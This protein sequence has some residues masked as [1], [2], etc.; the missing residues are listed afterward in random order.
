MKL[1]CFTFSMIFLGLSYAQEGQK[2]E[3]KVVAATVF[4][5]RA[6]ITREAEQ[7][8]TKGEHTL[9]FSNLISD[10]QDE[11]VRLQASG[12]GVIKILDVK[13][14][15]R[16]T[17][18]I[19][20]QRTR[21]L[22]QQI[23]SL[24]A[25]LQITNDKL[26]VLESKKKFVEALQAESVKTTN[27]SMLSNTVSPKN[28]GEMLRFVDISL[29]EI[30]SGLREQNVKKQEIEQEIRA[31]QLTLSQ[32]QGG[33][34]KDYKEIIVKIE[35]SEA[36]KIKLNP[37]YLVSSASWYPSYDA[38]VLSKSKQIELTYTG[39]MQQ[40]TGEDWNEVKLTFSTA[41]PLTVK[42]LPELTSW[43]LD[44]RPLPLS[45]A[46]RDAGIMVSSDYPVSYDQNYG[47]PRGRGN[48]SGYITDKETGDP[49]PGAN[50]YLKGT[51]LGAAADMNGKFTINNVPRGYY[52]LV[53]SYVG[54]QTVNLKLEVIEKNI[55]N[56]VM[57]L[58]PAAME[59]E[60]IAVTAQRALIKK[61][62]TSSIQSLDGVL[63]MEKPAPEKPKYTN[64]YA[65]ELSTV[66][67]LPA[68]NSIPSDNSP[69]KVTIAIDDLPIEFEYNAIPKILPKVYLKGKMINDKAYPLLEGQINV[70][71]DNDFVN[72][73][74]L[75][76]IVP[77][78]TLELALG[79]DESIRAEKILIKK[80]TE[81]KGMFG[82]KKKITYEYELRLTNNRQTEEIVWLYDQL[83]IPMNENIKVELLEPQ[84]EKEEL[85]NELKLEW[86]LK[87]KPGEKKIIPLKYQVEFPKNQTVYGLE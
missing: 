31:L 33:K 83:P 15:R 80:F 55:A 43:Y 71:V 82:G 20:E 37:S 8:L 52:D 76:T 53:V 75:N 68:K 72:R 78:D 73:T 2:V 57:P 21:T 13:T 46:D 47:L 30:F 58:S 64:V 48:I 86:Q 39:V 66:F 40:S 29:N 38:R 5:D 61:D 45:A 81:S 17:T 16:F 32:S 63:M 59:A 41:D 23:N 56:V 50:V 67:E 28:W 51:Q 12:P 22:Q 62:M 42:S 24:A 54:Y 85:G 65:K 69:H 60:E 35:N 19:Q 74:Y 77:S 11:S 34:S 26:A 25:Q 1:L 3:S 79:I 9:I 87:L 6:M 44:T 10:L 27:E 14:E 7:T 36:G 70:F 49:L 18:Q 4:K 84:K